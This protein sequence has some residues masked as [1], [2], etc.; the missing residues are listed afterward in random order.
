MSSLDYLRNILNCSRVN[1]NDNDNDS[2]LISF[3]EEMCGSCCIR[4]NTNVAKMIFSRNNQCHF[5]GEHRTQKH[6]CHE[7]S[8]LSQCTYIAE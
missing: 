1:T 8:P 3:Y 7:M 2:E 5:E 6:I 4:N